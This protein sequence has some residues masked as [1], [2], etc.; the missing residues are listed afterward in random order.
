MKTM[1]PLRLQDDIDLSTTVRADR[2]NEYRTV[3][4]QGNWTWELSTEQ[5]R[6][7]VSGHGR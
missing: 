2:D 6:D 3:Q 1:S 7:E 5:Y 4:G